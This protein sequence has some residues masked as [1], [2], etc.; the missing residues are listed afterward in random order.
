MRQ[1]GILGYESFGYFISHDIYEEWALEKIIEREYNNRSDNNSFFINIGSSLPIRRSFRSWLSEKL[2]LNYENVKAFIEEMI[3]AKDVESF[4]KDEIFISILLSAYSDTFFHNFERELKTDDFALLKRLSFLLRLACK[5][6]DN[7]LIEQ[8]KLNG[9]KKLEMFQLFN[10]PKGNG[11]KSFIS[12]IFNNIDSFE[13]KDISFILPII[14]EWNSKRKNGEATRY[15]SLIALSYYESLNDNDKLIRTILY[16]ANEIKN[17]LESIFKNVIENEYRNSRDPYYY[18]CKQ[19]LT[20]IEFVNV[21]QILPK[22]ILQISDLLW[23]KPP[24][25]KLNS[26]NRYDY[27][28]EERYNLVNEHDFKYFPASAFQTPLYWCLKS[29]QHFTLEFI[30]NFTNKAIESFLKSKRNGRPVKEVKLLVGDNEVV[31]VH[32]SG[33]WGM[34]RGL[35]NSPYLLQSIHMALEKYLLE[36]SRSLEQESLEI[37]LSYLLLK[38]K[39]SSITAVVASIVVAY[40]EKTFNIAFIL[41]KVKDF[42]ECDFSR[43]TQEY[44]SHFDGAYDTMSKIYSLER[45]EELKR[46]HRKESLSGIMFKYQLINSEDG[47][48]KKKLI[49]N[50][51]DNY[52]VD[53]EK[54]PSETQSWKL[55]ILTKIDVRKMGM[56]HEKTSTNENIISF[57]PQLDEK[58]KDYQQSVL[59]DIDDSNKYNQLSMWADYKLRNDDKFKKYDIYSSNIP[60]VFSSIKEILVLFKDENYSRLFTEEIPSK[61]SC[62]LLRDFNE[63]LEDKERV[64]CKE[65]F[66]NHIFNTSDNRTDIEYYINVLPSLIKIFPQEKNDIKFKLLE[67]LR[68]GYGIVSMMEM[69]KTHYQDIY[70]ITIAYLILEPLYN[71]KYNEYRRERY[72]S[73][74]RKEFN[75]ATVWDEV[76]LENSEII[77][78]MNNNELSFDNVADFNSINIDILSK[79]FNILPD[80]IN[81]QEVRDLS[82]TL[83]SIIS[84]KM[85]LDKDDKV[86]YEIRDNFCTKLSYIMLNSKNDEIDIYLDLIIGNFENSEMIETLFNELIKAQSILNKYEVFWYIWMKFQDVIIC[87]CEKGDKYAFINKVVYSYLFSN[88]NILGQGILPDS[89]KSWHTLKERDKRFFKRMSENIGHCPSTLYSISKLLTSVGSIYL[90]DGISWIANMLKNNAN[91]YEDELE[92]NT[93]Y[94]L[95]TLIRKF[96][97]ENTQQIKKVRKIKEDV[98]VILDFLIGK[99]SSLGYMLREKVL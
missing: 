12:F 18:L 91:L 5:E 13:L 69:W 56:K 44:I 24:K 92:V 20:Q 41:F 98:L 50:I 10:K 73:E 27:D 78:K 74:Y 37:L 6:V 42:L 9:T 61:C 57:T 25:R 17:E 58:S 23:F 40:P 84:T 87:L 93:I 46:E 4:W 29:E 3:D 28:T 39:S 16:G 36:I 81:T 11:W 97:F 75:I 62:I 88:H 49:E 35:N 7:S 95:E 85:L 45:A 32:S 15:A 21:A 59:K 83:N 68:L 82:Y 70:S 60:L 79:V 47:L 51:I 31:Q 30:L 94:H 72:N 76:L 8:Y 65:L 53:I 19:L 33:L 38:S 77:E 80:E 66:L 90:K 63:S 86:G 43:S 55:F 52:Y 89:W 2:L 1:E 71:I 14:Y 99:G 64:F 26:F 54:E 22:H 96:I 48:E 67:L 34:Y